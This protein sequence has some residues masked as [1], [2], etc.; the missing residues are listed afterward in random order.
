[1]SD[2]ERLPLLRGRVGRVERYKSPQGGSRDKPLLPP[3]D[4][5]TH[6]AHLRSQLDALKAA[7]AARAPAQRDS[8]A[9]RE[10]VAVIP[11]P[12]QSLPAESLGDK[13]SDV[14]VI[15]EDPD[16]GLVLLDAKSADLAALRG[17]VALYGDPAKDTDSGNPKNAPLLAP[18]KRLGLAGVSDLATSPSQLD[19]VRRPRWLA[20]MCRGGR[21]DQ[22]AA[23]ASRAQLNR[24]LHSLFGLRGPEASFEGA[25][26]TAFYVKLSVDQLGQLIEAVDCIYEFD[27]AE[28]E[29]RDWLLL[30]ERGIDLSDHQQTP[31]P[32]DAP[33]VVILDTGIQDTHPLLAPS[34]LSATSVL[35]GIESGVDA[36]GHGTQMAGIALFLDGVG[37]AV[38]AGSSQASHWLQSVRILERPTQSNSSAEIQT[39]GARTI[40]A[41][42]NAEALEGPSARAFAMAVTSPVEEL[43]P[44]DWS[45]AVEQLAWNQGQGRL[46]CISAGKSDH[47]SVDLIRGYPKASLEQ[48]IHDPAQAW[49]AL[50][51]GACTH[52]VEMP[53]DEELLGYKP[54][55]SAGGISPLTT[56]RPA[57][58]ERVPNKP[59]IVMEG[60]NMAFDGTLPDATIDTLCAITTHH[61]RDKP[62][63]T[64]NGTSEATAR[65]ANLAAR[66]WTAEPT[67]TPAT[68]RGLM[69]HSASWTPTMLEQFPDLDHR[70]AVC[71][72]GEPD[73]EFA[74]ACTEARAT[75]IVEGTM[76]NAVEVERLKDPPPKR[77]TTKK[78]ETVLQRRAQ[79][80]SLPLN[81]ALLEQH[82][83]ADVELRVTLS[84]FPEI[85]AF[86]RSAYRGL[87]LKW[88]MQGP[89]EGE[90]RFRARINK[91]VREGGEKGGDPYD[92]DLRISRRQ[93]GTVQSDRWRGKAIDLGPRL[94]AVVPVLGWWDRRKDFQL[95]EQ[96]YSL[97]VSVI[98]PGL[99][100]YNSVAIGLEAESE[101]EV[102]VE[103]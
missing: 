4:R 19:A 48:S 25:L 32:A 80:F 98:A 52:R 41:A 69:V 15:G 70:M 72:Y 77:S 49:N 58:A 1:M 95:K 67:L 43:R 38:E 6:A 47:G 90:D 91:L 56:A 20:L 78:T 3:R 87:D 37:A 51:V 26:H 66:I 18:I 59:D 73:A 28:R 86:R 50:T 11:E 10:I 75:V 92:W 42:E 27:P 65:A 23:R 83:D 53:P 93:N 102:E 55:G 9:T 57:N 79:Y 7:A 85:H 34:I 12:G 2:E 36:H 33:A 54:V 45:Q 60:G 76:P 17:K 39:W 89:A 99:N 21:H 35:P 68:V 46:I 30:E 88:Y 84:Y 40:K 63:W 97:L 24:Q 29:I 61:R 31:P 74:L 8:D 16:T 82:A 44:T 100:I 5:A 96:P 101:A 62:L 14:R 13:N 103:V 64:I 94:I 71:G 81:D 22:E